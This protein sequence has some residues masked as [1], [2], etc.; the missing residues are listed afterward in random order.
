MAKRKILTAQLPPTPC[1]PEMRSRV[2]ELA[3]SEGRS[4]A[5]I[6]RDAITLFLRRHDRKSDKSDT[7]TTKSKEN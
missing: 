2:V 5:E 1:T 6:Q 3:E 7:K 4:I